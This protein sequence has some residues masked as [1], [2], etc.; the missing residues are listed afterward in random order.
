MIEY[1]VEYSNTIRSHLISFDK[2]AWKYLLS[3]NQTFS[4]LQQLDPTL[5]SMINVL[6]NTVDV[7]ISRSAY[8][9]TK[10][11]IHSV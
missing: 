7:H 1:L 4:L 8:T 3:Y 11:L 6:L 9:D 10:Y 5:P 2:S